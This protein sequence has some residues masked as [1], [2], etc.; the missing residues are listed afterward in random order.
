MGA[1]QPLVF[2]YSLFEKDGTLTELLF[3]GLPQ[4]RFKRIYSR[5]L[6]FIL[7]RDVALSANPM[8]ISEE[9]RQLFYP[10]SQTHFSCLHLPSD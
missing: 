2:F 4:V 7:L 3:T 6:F 9:S 10:A 5:Q 8:T 1:S